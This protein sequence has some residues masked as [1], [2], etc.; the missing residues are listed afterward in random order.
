[1]KSEESGKHYH[2]IVKN[3]CWAE[4]VYLIKLIFKNVC[5]IMRY[6]FALSRLAIIRRSENWKY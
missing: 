2:G 3:K 1:M 6:H 5:K 4:T